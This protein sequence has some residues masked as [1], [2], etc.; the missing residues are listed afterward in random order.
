MC[1]LSLSSDSVVVITVSLLVIGL[2]YSRVV[3]GDVFGSDELLSSPVVVGRGI[4]STV[5]VAAVA[6]GTVVVCGAVVVGG[7]VVVGGAV[8][9][10]GVMMSGSVV[11]SIS[12]VV[13]GAVVIISGSGIV[14]LKS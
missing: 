1:T 13:G 9:V 8:V 10:G 3:G 2:E 11:V 5:D 14:M 12:V 6:G 7:T 4:P